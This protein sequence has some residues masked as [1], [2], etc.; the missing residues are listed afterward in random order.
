M[1]WPMSFW[2]A[3]SQVQLDFLLL[4]VWRFTCPITLLIVNQTSGLNSLQEESVPT[5]A[6]IL[7]AYLWA[8]PLVHNDH[9]S[10]SV[11]RESIPLQI[12]MHSWGCTS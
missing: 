1:S 2:V 9:Q 12:G 10:T 8:N 5:P 6:C 11:L 4:K 3:S 7:E